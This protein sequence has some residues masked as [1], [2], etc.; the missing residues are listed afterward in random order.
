MDMKALKVFLELARTGSLRQT[1]EKLNTSPA[2]VSRKLDQLEYQFR[3]QL[4]DRSHSGGKLTAAGEVLLGR[5]R[6]IVAEMETTLQLVSDLKSLNTGSTTVYAGG[7]IVAELLAPALCALH[8][9]HPGLRFHIHEGRTSELIDA[10]R[11]GAADVGVA[12]FTPEAGSPFVRRSVPL[13]HALIVAPGHPLTLQTHVRIQDLARHAIAI[14]DESFSLRRTLDAEC[15]RHGVTLEPTFVTGSLVMQK[16]LAIRG[17]AALVL[18]PECCRRE[19]EAGLLTSIPFKRP[20]LVRTQ[21]DLCVHPDRV[22]PFAAKTLHDTLALSLLR[23]AE[24]RL[25]L[26]SDIP[27]E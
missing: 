20:D 4:F 15:L 18:P 25:A 19:I 5:A 1:A 10:L 9:Q 11:Q 12:I 22:L 6:L 14:P 8:R 27:E 3:T 24:E 7:A 17:A 2:S 26:P 21:L 13:D 23:R 16:E